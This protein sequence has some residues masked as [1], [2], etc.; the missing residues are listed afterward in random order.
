[1]NKELVL[2]V[3]NKV[4]SINIIISIVQFGELLQTSNVKHLPRSCLL[5][6]VFFFTFPD[7]KNDRKYN[8][9]LL[10]LGYFLSHDNLQF[11]PFSYKQH[12]ILP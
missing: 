11:Y 5:D 1:M 7:S 3:L 4:Q 8:S 9:S 2:K 6:S 12:F 10:G